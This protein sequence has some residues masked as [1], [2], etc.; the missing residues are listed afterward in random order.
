MGTRV[1]DVVGGEL[2]GFLVESGEK[3]LGKGNFGHDVFLKGRVEGGLVDGGGGIVHQLG[4]DEA[5]GLVEVSYD[6]DDDD[7]LSGIIAPPTNSLIRT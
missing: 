7:C 2:D 1:G 4:S 5:D 6:D 3:G